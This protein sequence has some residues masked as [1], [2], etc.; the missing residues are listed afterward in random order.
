M[1]IICFLLVLPSFF[2]P[3]FSL[4]SRFSG[5]GDKL[6]TVRID[7]TRNLLYTLSDKSVIRLYDLGKND[8]QTTEVFVYKNLLRDAEV[9]C[10]QLNKFSN[11]PSVL[12]LVDIHP[13]LMT[14][15]STMN[16][17]AVA[18]SGM[19]FYFSTSNVYEV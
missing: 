6:N 13:I 17:V 16:L 10:P 2:L 19:R 4:C 7:S 9:K 18:K 11:T 14:E 15:S 1:N 8:D 12:Q 3:H 5:A